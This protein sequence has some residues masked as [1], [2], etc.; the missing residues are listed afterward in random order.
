MQHFLHN[1]LH[2]VWYL[3]YL[4]QIQHNILNTVSIPQLSITFSDFSTRECFSNSNIWNIFCITHYIKFDT[5]NICSSFR[6]IHYI[7]FRYLKYL[8]HF[9]TFTQENV[10]ETQISVSFS[11]F[12]I[13]K[14]FDNSNIYSIFGVSHY[15]LFWYLKYLQNF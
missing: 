14:C 15:I 1:T 4:Q 9:K 13:T 5:S 12:H 8:Q 11:A 2:K 3:K 7:N 6:I 10:S